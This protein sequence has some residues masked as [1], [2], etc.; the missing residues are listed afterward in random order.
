MEHAAKPS[1]TVP[2]TI[3]VKLRYEVYCLLQETPV[4]SEEG[5]EFRSVSD[6]LHRLLNVYRK[7]VR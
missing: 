1:K 4:V 7:T 3:N 5:I 2:K 6:K